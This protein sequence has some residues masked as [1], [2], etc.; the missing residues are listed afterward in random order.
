MPGRVIVGGHIG[1]PWTDEMI[2]VATKYEDVFIDT[3]AYKP[4]RYPPA[5]VEF[6]RGHGAKKVL[7]G[8]NCPMICP[9]ACLAQVE[10]LGLS[11]EAQRL[12]LHDNAA[13]IFT[14]T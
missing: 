11:E 5:L 6:M 1:Y 12:F 10:E 9:A 7:Y 4:K 2:A 14:R 8:S 3:S 13:R